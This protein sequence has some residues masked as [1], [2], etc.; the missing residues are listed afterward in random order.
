MSELKT[1]YSTKEEIRDELIQFGIDAATADILAQQAKPA[2]WLETRKVDD[3]AAIAIGATKLG[4]RPD[5]PAN[6]ALPRRPAY[7][8]AEKRTNYI[9]EEISDPDKAWSWAKPEQ[10]E[11]IR[12]EA[13]EHIRMVESEQPLSFVAQ[14][15]LAE[16]WA[17]GTLDPDIPQRG[18][19][20]I[21]YDMVEQPWGFAPS[22]RIGFAILFHEDD[23]K[24]VRRDEPD[25]LRSLPSS[26][27]LSPVACTAHPCITPLPLKSAQYSDLGLSGKLTDQ[28]WDWWSEDA[29]LYSSENGEDW[30]CH[31]IGGW[32]TPVQGDMQIE[33]ALVSAGHNCDAFAYKDSALASIRATAAD[34]LLLAQ[35][36]TDEKGGMMWGDDG[37]L[38]VWIRRDDLKARRF[39]NAHLILQ[40]Y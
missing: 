18:I 11:E 15:N 14:I 13:I 34:W 4:G 6:T 19:V 20:S 25:E 21:F 24:L 36:G 32:A 40:C 3:E 12:Q 9:R 35:I 5:L 8:D 10:R 16:M 29:H 30:K 2:V 1:V 27:R 33:C 39:E 22:D 38:Y 31:H 17:A 7:P 37:Q 26:Y 28:L 23:S